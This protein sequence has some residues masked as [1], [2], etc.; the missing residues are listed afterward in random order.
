LSETH[1]YYEQN[2]EQ[3]FADTIDVDMSALYARF[4]EAIPE[5]GA[6]Q[7]APRSAGGGA[8]LR[9]CCPICWRG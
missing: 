3:F 6:G 2:A 1:N 8:Q 7:P 9:C 5:G 4:L